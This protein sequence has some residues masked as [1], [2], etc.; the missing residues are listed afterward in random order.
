MENT[1][2]FFVL[3]VFK[4]APGT[5][6]APYFKDCALSYS[7]EGAFI[8]ADTAEKKSYLRAV[9]A[10]GKNISSAGYRRVELADREGFKWTE[11]DAMSFFLGFR[12]IK[13]G[14]DIV[15]PQDLDT[16]SFRT[17][18]SIIT[19]LRDT[20]DEPASA[21]NPVS[22][23]V[24]LNSLN[25]IT[26]NALTVK[27]YT[28]D[29]L[30]SENLTG[31]M[32]V[33]GGSDNPPC[34]YE[35]DYNPTGDE[36]APVFAALVGKGITFDTGGY[37]LK[38]SE[39]MRSMHTDMGGS[40]TVAAS[41]ALLAVSGFDR[42][43]KAWLC[44]AENMV[45]GKAM[46]VGDV[47]SYPNGVSVVI[48]NTDAEG[49]LV[50]ADGLIRAGNSG[51][52]YIIDAATLTGAAKVAL[53]RDYNAAMSLNADLSSEFVSSAASVNE[54]AWPLPFDKFHL[55]LVSS[56]LADITNSAS[57]DG[58]A[59]ATSAASFLSRFVPSEKWNSW[60]HIDL[61]ASYRKTPND[62]YQIGAMGHGA[63]SVAAFIRK[64]A[65]R[66]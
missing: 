47:I 58:I 16:E 45:S 24:Y 62:I 29:R 37:S 2:D 39:L 15:Y 20:I 49:R 57:G 55:G 32:T 56:Q 50:L 13:N 31:L 54:Y 19:W 14:A 43:V 18:R 46:R 36:N 17:V 66:R 3:K 21:L 34:L 59:G 38:P 60:L 30:Q 33:G 23:I 25:A 48:D 4:A 65:G 7:E 42:R 6:A 9:Q 1:E 51:A 26:G 52:E 12:S 28:G 63:R 41:L 40:A 44:C 61:A 64:L 22:Y 27:A 5:A 8:H 35:L 53:G 10:A 11:E